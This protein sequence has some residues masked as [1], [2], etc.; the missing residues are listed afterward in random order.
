MDNASVSRESES[1]TEQESV[2]SL[3]EM[4]Q[5]GWNVTVR[6]LADDEYI[7]SAEHRDRSAH[8]NGLSATSISLALETLAVICRP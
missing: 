2:V 3:E 1:M 5:S 7:A 6:R 4:L 8:R